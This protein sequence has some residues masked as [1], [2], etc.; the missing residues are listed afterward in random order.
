M[1]TFEPPNTSRFIV[2]PT[3]GA[4]VYTEDT[5]EEQVVQDVRSDE[6][7]YRA[8]YQR[9]KT[10]YNLCKN[11]SGIG[12]VLLTIPAFLTLLNQTWIWLSISYSILI[13]VTAVFPQL[14][15]FVDKCEF[16]Q[17]AYME[18]EKERHQ[19]KKA[20]DPDYKVLTSQGRFDLLE[21]RRQGIRNQIEISLRP[22][23]ITRTIGS[24]STS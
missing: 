8:K 12:A 22:R 13:A 18:L 2:T 5:G 10:A 16:Y 15:R 1:N 23:G 6:E 7:E 21:S 14:N 11:I 19:C 20:E 17:Q 24:N 3:P 9:Y 4:I